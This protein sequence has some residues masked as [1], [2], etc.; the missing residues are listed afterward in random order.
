M[1]EVRPAAAVGDAPPPLR[2]E[3]TRER[4]LAAASHLFATQGFDG[5]SVEAVAAAADLTVPGMYRHFPGKDQ[6]LV[7]V[8][9]RVTRL[10]RARQALA[11]G[12][13]LAGGL[14]ALFEEYLEAGQIERRRLS[15]ELSRASFQNAELHDALVGFNELLRDSLTATIVGATS[16]GDERE[17]ALLSHLLLVI[18]MGAVHLD[19][20]D[21]ERV[22]DAR[23]TAFLRRRFAVLIAEPGSPAPS[24]RRLPSTTVD[25]ASEPEPKDGRRARSVRTRHRIL[26]AAEELFALHG[27]DATTI[28]MLAARAEITVPGLY[29]HMT[30]KEALLVDVAQRAFSR[31][32]LGVPF[33]GEAG[34]ADQLADLLAAFSASGERVNRRLAVELDFGA[35]RNA[36]LA[37]GLTDFH[38]RVRRNV[39][40]SLS[41]EEGVPTDDDHELRALVAL[42]VFM[43]IAHLD[44]VDPGLID[45]RGWTDLLRR[46][47]PQLVG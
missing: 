13:D 8:A 15:I 36:A 37:A 14:A 21:P 4:V 39:A 26:A 11:T 20:L 5:T 35:W 38:R 16:A 47:V 12:T 25:T 40:S 10:S 9:R 27:Y 22:G 41:A 32:R 23:L 42:M 46:R 29:R 3:A 44:T 33:A 34:V 18:L 17:A 24:R 30:S 1:A 45:D 2:G 6:L 7:S 28:E 19:T 31:Y 43:G